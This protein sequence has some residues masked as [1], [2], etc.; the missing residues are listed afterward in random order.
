MIK[1]YIYLRNY[2]FLSEPTNILAVVGAFY[3]WGTAIIL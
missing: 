1:T 3:F 2:K